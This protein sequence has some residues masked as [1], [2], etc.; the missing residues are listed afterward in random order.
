MSVN[1]DG[2]YPV[3][4]ADGR[5]VLANAVVSVDSTGTPTGGGSTSLAGKFFSAMLTDDGTGEGDSNAAKDYSGSAGRVYLLVPDGYQINIYLIRMYYV[6]TGIA[7]TLTTNFGNI[8]TLMNGVEIATASSDGESTITT[9]W[10]AEDLR[11]N[12]DWFVKS[13]NY[14]L[15]TASGTSSKQ[16]YVRELSSPL[17]VVAGTCFQVMMHDN[18]SSLTS[19]RFEIEGRLIQV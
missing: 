7:P 4:L 2:K 12:Y 14:M 5:T 8:A 9:L 18:L 15:N 6:W 10:A 13:Q 19:L 3:T 1:A 16:C 11:T 17:T